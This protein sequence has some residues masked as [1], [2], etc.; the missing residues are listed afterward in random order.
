MGTPPT[1]PRITKG[2]IGSGLG[3]EE[4]NPGGIG[5]SVSGQGGEP[6]GEKSP[7]VRALYGG[8]ENK[9]VK[10]FGDT[11]REVGEALLSYVS[12]C[13]TESGTRGKLNE[14]DRRLVA[15]VKAMSGTAEDLNFN[16]VKKLHASDLLLNRLEP[17]EWVMLA[18][19]LRALQEAKAMVLGAE[20]IPQE[21]RS[22]RVRLP[23]RLIEEGK[24]FALGMTAERV[25]EMRE[26]GRALVAAI[27]PDAVANK[28]TQE[29]WRN[30]RGY[31]QQNV[32]GTSY[33]LDADKL[34]SAGLVGFV[35]G[36]S[37]A[38]QAIDLAKLIKARRKFVWCIMGGPEGRNS[39]AAVDNPHFDRFSQE[40][41]IEL[42]KL[43]TKPEFEYKPEEIA[44][45]RIRAALEANKVVATKLCS[46]AMVDW[47]KTGGPAPK[48]LEEFDDALGKLGGAETEEQR[49]KRNELE[50]NV[51]GARRQH[52]EA[53][54]AL[55][56]TESRLTGYT[57]RL[58][59]LDAEI[60]KLG[61]EIDDLQVAV[62]TQASNK[63]PIDRVIGDL[64]KEKE[65]LRGNYTKERGD[66]LS[67]KQPNDSGKI[68]E[69][70]T[71]EAN[72]K[73]AWE[74]AEAEL[75]KL[76]VSRTPETEKVKLRAEALRRIIGTREKE[77]VI[78]GSQTTKE[79]VE[80]SM[81]DILSNLAHGTISLDGL[82][83][84]SNRWQDNLRLIRKW[85]GLEEEVFD[86]AMGPNEAYFQTFLVKAL[87]IP[88][89][90][91]KELLKAALAKSPKPDQKKLL[92]EVHDGIL[93]VIRDKGYPVLG[94]LAFQAWDALRD[95]FVRY[96]IE[97]GM[98]IDY[99]T[100]PSVAEVVGPVKAK[101]AESPLSIALKRQDFYPGINTAVQYL[102]LA[103]GTKLAIVGGKDGENIVFDVRGRR[104]GTL[105]RQNASGSIEGTT[106]PNLIR[107]QDEIFAALVFETIRSQVESGVTT[108]LG[109]AL[110]KKG[111]IYLVKNKPWQ[112]YFQAY[113]D[114]LHK[115]ALAAIK[116]LEQ[117]S[118]ELRAQRK[119]TGEFTPRYS[120]YQGEF[121]LYDPNANIADPN[122]REVLVQFTKEGIKL[123]LIEVKPLAP[124]LPWLPYTINSKDGDPFLIDANDAVIGAAGSSLGLAEISS[125]RKSLLERGFF[126]LTL[127]ERP[128]RIPNT[129]ID[130]GGGKVYDFGIGE[131][132]RLVRWDQSGKEEMAM[133]ALNRDYRLE[134]LKEDDLKKIRQELGMTYLKRL[135]ERWKEAWR[136]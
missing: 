52:E 128:G 17:G 87:E 90:D 64:I 14:L 111:E 37:L 126:A 93:E 43:M 39:K 19:T 131:N 96:G 120:K 115:I 132:G 18:D 83:D 32:K 101:V 38:E 123:Q 67:D 75:K 94:G 48:A 84:D 34:E 116:D 53:Q 107:Q 49:A 88:G 27:G 13:F 7:K 76:G 108:Y 79:T 82:S 24:R 3:G 29:E 36:R 121:R 127:E 56:Q 110:K 11:E 86:G 70:K 41:D 44:K 61:I 1:A 100:I 133:E 134:V 50:T 95:S 85:I 23:A 12:C 28:R 89:V 129:H 60:E 122:Y 78:I 30:L 119:A 125:L 35:T 109:L 136:L 33:Q 102:T 47:V 6:Q 2:A 113:P 40:M 103:D 99:G 59:I 42:K 97:H 65:R 118:N 10:P 57:N 21:E 74:K 8:P 45:L 71:N 20:L 72:T 114:D 55:S 51:N 25:K 80:G 66:I 112:E 117:R 9:D 77:I 63:Q 15:L 91:P 46:K 31:L 5:R 124:G 105:E 68:S 81:Y 54:N 22:K 69:L 58:V 92:K 130:L 16:S 4:S 104:L 73:K 98:R 26:T 106:T 62:R 135:H